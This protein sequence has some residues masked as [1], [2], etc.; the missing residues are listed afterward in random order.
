MGRAG[1]LRSRPVGLTIGRLMLASV[2]VAVGLWTFRA[3]VR[4]EPITR[5]EQI[6]MIAIGVAIVARAFIVVLYAGRC[7]VCDKGPVGRVAAVSFGD[8]FY[9]CSACGQRMKRSWLGRTWDA[10]GPED[11]RRFHKD[12]PVS[13]WSD[14]PIYPSTDSP[15]TR[16]VGSL[17]R[18]KVDREAHVPEPVEIASGEAGW[19]NES[20]P[21][22]PSKPRAM[23][24]APLGVK[25]QVARSFFRTLEAIRWD[26]NS[27]R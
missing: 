24:S 9:R 14:G 13:T 12:R 6:G 22:G 25:Q 2:A 17:L 10:S 27:R 3:I 18:G 5:G 4:A 7:S 1:P 16:T 20:A 11:D 15:E 21:D 8:H 19:R 23:R 26:R